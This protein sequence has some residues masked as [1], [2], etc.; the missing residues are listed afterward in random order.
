MWNGM[1]LEDS[2]SFKPETSLVSAINLK[3]IPE[4]LRLIEAGVDVNEKSGYY[5]LIALNLAASTG[6]L[7]LMA[8]LLDRGARVDIRNESQ[9]TPL[10]FAVQSAHVS[11]VKMLIEYGADV[12]ATSNI[13]ETPLHLAVSRLLANPMEDKK[14]MIAML[15]NSGA[16]VNASNKRGT[17]VLM[18]AVKSNNPGVIS[19]LLKDPMLHINATDNEGDT[20][21]H[22]AI[23][24]SEMEIVKLLLLDGA[25]IDIKDNDGRT[26]VELAEFLDNSAGMPLNHD[27]ISR[28]LNDVKERILA[29]TLQRVVAMGGHSRAADSPFRNLPPGLLS[30]ILKRDKQQ[31]AEKSRYDRFIDDVVT[32]KLKDTIEKNRV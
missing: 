18:Q 13:G 17:T 2:E 14:A 20:A 31:Q 5:K 4:A 3:N 32:R 7:E 12:S 10:F 21:L 16:N 19:I 30:H 29:R 8:A 28:L 15:L 27:S 11:A 25:S 6:Q 26:A 23:S 24:R 22:H 9:L 1:Y